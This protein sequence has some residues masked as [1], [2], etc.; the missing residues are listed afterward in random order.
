MG[1]RPPFA[2]QFQADRTDCRKQCP[3]SAARG[4]PEAP[5]VLTTRMEAQT[6]PTSHEDAFVNDVQYD[7]YG[8]RLATCGRDRKIEVGEDDFPCG[9][10]NH[11]RFCVALHFHPRTRARTRRTAVPASASVNVALAPEY[12]TN[13]RTYTHRHTQRTRAQTHAHPPTPTNI[14]VRPE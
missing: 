7:F 4:V 8:R 3:P 9:R 14:G 13:P 2:R 11:P 1:E 10:R 12:T 6:I 5:P